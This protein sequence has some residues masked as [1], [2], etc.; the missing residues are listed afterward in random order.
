M[1][2]LSWAVFS[3]RELLL[4][5]AAHVFLSTILAC[6]PCQTVHFGKIFA[7]A[8]RNAFELGL[9]FAWF[10]VPLAPSQTRAYYN[11]V[12]KTC[13]RGAE[14][15]LQ[16]RL[17]TGVM[18]VSAWKLPGCHTIFMIVTMNIRN[19]L[20]KSQSTKVFSSYNVF[21]HQW[22]MC[23]C[24]ISVW[25]MG[26]VVAVVSSCTWLVSVQSATVTCTRQPIWY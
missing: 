4:P 24:P 14:E 1:L 17:H 25:L 9:Q 13:P 5:Y 18:S 26:N 11:F 16:R 20:K 19:I 2:P 8:K 10:V 12:C 7:V 3:H 22:Y 15:V 23:I 21:Q 6:L